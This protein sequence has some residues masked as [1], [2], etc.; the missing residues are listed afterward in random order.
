MKNPPNLSQL[1]TSSKIKFEDSEEN[2]S[3]SKENESSSEASE[4]SSDNE[5]AEIKNELDDLTFEEMHKALADGT[6]ALHQKR[7]S[8]NKPRRA[9]KNRPMEVSSTKR[10]S[11]FREVIQAPKKVARDPRF[12]SLC[13]KFDEEGF[14]K[15]YNFIYEESLPAEKEKLQ[16]QLRSSEDP[17][18]IEELENRIAWIDK[19]MKADST[20]TKTRTAKIMSEHKKRA[21]EAVK[22]GKRPFYIKKS[23]VRKQLH[24]EKYNKLKASGK[25]DS[26]LENKRRR[27]A[28]KDRKFMPYRR[29]END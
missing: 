3:S 6:V 16:K 7:R 27:N 23:E 24:I 29:P 19:Q 1:P 9:N 10:V 4:F 2:E 25:L 8:Q 11:R 12:E 14:K 28:A 21:R 15:R 13:G 17:R 26:F 18:V 5:E 22:Q 20:K